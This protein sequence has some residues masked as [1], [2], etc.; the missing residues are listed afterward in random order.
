VPNRNSAVSLPLCVGHR[1]RHWRP[2]FGEVN[3]KT[4]ALQPPKADRPCRPPLK[5]EEELGAILR[6]LLVSLPGM[7]L[8]RENRGPEQHRGL[9]TALVVHYAE[10]PVACRIDYLLVR[11]LTRNSE[12]V[13]K[14]VPS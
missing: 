11:R 14:G 12:H 8:V 3:A 2:V 9:S 13:G 6:K 4:Q 1:K 10:Y 5:V 7:L